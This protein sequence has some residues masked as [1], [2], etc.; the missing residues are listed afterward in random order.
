ML[1]HRR[2][3]TLSFMA[4]SLNNGLADKPPPTEMAV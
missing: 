2:S 4:L 3:G 1:G